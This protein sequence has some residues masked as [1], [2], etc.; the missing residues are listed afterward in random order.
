MIQS[1][2][3]FR[4]FRITLLI[5]VIALVLQYVL[6]MFVNLYVQ[7]PDSLPG[8]NAFAWANT[9]SALIQIHIYL[10]T[11]LLVL[12]LITLGLSIALK[13]IWRVLMSLAGLLLIFFSYT[14]GILF[15]IN[16]QENAPSMWMAVGMIGA[17]VVYGFEYYLTRPTAYQKKLHVNA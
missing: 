15:L 17:L 5:I 12:P 2:K 11:L 8:G 7:F 1:N 9:H 6:G 13:D 16:V 4:A 10:G 3:R 14:G